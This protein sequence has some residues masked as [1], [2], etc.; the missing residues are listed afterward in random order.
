MM[1]VVCE[2]CLRHQHSA[3]CKMLLYVT[4]GNVM[5]NQ[6]ISLVADSG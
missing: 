3:G 5:T 2:P 4:D 1:H 6:S